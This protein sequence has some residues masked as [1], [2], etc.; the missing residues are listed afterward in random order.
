[1]VVIVKKA[2]FNSK[3]HKLTGKPGSISSIDGKPFWGTDGPIPKQIITS[4]K[5]I[6]SGK[7]ILIP[8][9]AYNDLYEPNLSTLQ[10]YIGK[11]NTIYV[12][13]DNSDGA[14][15]YSIIWII[16]NNQ[17]FKRYIDNS[18]A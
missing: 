5:I 4:V 12:E 13:M 15:A 6:I 7:S 8:I 1:M 2:A 3:K 17:Y 9:N 11:D 18:D 10:I 14:G 16:K